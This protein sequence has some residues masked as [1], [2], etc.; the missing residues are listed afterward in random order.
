MLYQKHYF[1]KL[2][3]PMKFVKN[4]LLLAACLYYTTAVQAQ[5][6]I[7]WTQYYLSPVTLNPALTGAYQGSYRIGG[8]YRDQ[9]NF[10]STDGGKVN[11]YRTPSFFAD[12][13]LSVPKFM[14]SRQK[15][16]IGIGLAFY[17]DKAGTTNLGQTG[18]GLSL[19]YHLSLGKKSPAYLTFG[20]QSFGNQRTIDLG[21]AGVQFGTDIRG[22][23]N[24][25]LANITTGDK[26]VKY[27]D[28]KAGMLLTTRIDKKTTFNAGLA[29]QHLNKAYYNLYT[30]NAAKPNGQVPLLASV[31]ATMNRDITK[32]LSI[33]PT[34]LFQ[35]IKGSRELLLQALVGYKL[36]PNKDFK[37]I[38]GLGGRLGDSAQFLLGAETDKIR[39]GLAY[40]MTLS[41]LANNKTANGLEIA[42]IYT[43]KVYK[44]PVVKSKLVCP[45]Y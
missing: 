27:S 35:T 43:G 4:L 32:S 17:S 39:V 6:Q 44:K 2:Q 20:V 36:N 28:W 1:Y 33:M 30:L 16:W 19:A 3:L 26:G 29:L 24:P 38:G 45:R 7:H 14:K 22:A 10:I 42:V 25:D 41:S 12:V 13:P 34:V 9:D 15:D 5:Y 11:G 40:D 37:L 21:A 31:H 18:G 23:G 8:T